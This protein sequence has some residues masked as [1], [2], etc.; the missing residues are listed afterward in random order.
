VLDNGS[1]VAPLMHT[2]ATLTAAGASSNPILNYVT[3]KDSTGSG[4]WVTHTWSSTEVSDGSADQLVILA[5]SGPS[6]TGGFVFATAAITLTPDVGSDITPTLVIENGGAKWQAPYTAIAQF[7]LPAGA[8]SFTLQAVSDKS[9][10]FG[11]MRMF[12]F[13][14]PVADLQSTTATDAAIDLINA[15]TSVSVDLATEADGILVAVATTSTYNNSGNF[16]DSIAPSDETLTEHYDAAG[17]GI[18]CLM[19]SKSGTMDT[20]GEASNTVTL[21]SSASGNIRLAAAS[22]R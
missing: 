22:W 13:T 19:G 4:S 9:G 3:S 8:T 1:A 2:T 16:N 6:S 18:R 17:A 14:V 20:E 11:R 5:F 21:V 7:V 15:T 10:T 12:V